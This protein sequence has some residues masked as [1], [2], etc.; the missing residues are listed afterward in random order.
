MFL[1]G[2]MIEN[3]HHLNDLIT[4]LV[5]SKAI[6][7]RDYYHY[8]DHNKIVLNE[9]KFILN[10]KFCYRYRV[11]NISPKTPYIGRS[12]DH[13]NRIITDYVF[14][15]SLRYTMNSSPPWTLGWKYDYNCSSVSK[16]IMDII[17]RIPLKYRN[18][19]EYLT[20][21]ITS[22]IDSINDPVNG[23]IEGRWKSTFSRGK[24][25]GEWKTSGE[26]F[27][28]RINNKFPVRY[29]Q[30]WVLS[31]LLTGIFRFLGIPA[32]SVRIDNCIIDIYKSGGIDCIESSNGLNVK[33]HNKINFRHIIDEERYEFIETKNIQEIPSNKGCLF[34]LNNDIESNDKDFYG[35]DHHLG[36]RNHCWNF[37]VWTEVMIG[38]EWCIFDPS[39]LSSIEDFSP[40]ISDKRHPMMIG[41]KFLGPIPIKY[42]KEG[43]IPSNYPLTEN[44]KYLF[45]C[46][47]G[48]IRC[49]NPLQNSSGSRTIFYL[50][51]VNYDSVKVYERTSRGS[52][53]DIT[54]KYKCSYD[55]LHINNPLYFNITGNN[56]MEIHVFK[57]NHPIGEYIIQL[58]ILVGNTPLYIHREKVYDI[59]NMD[60]LLFLKDE[61]VMKYRQIADKI[62]VMIYDKKKDKV[63]FQGIRA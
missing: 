35:I 52:K 17:S 41:K 47:N 43:N 25:P 44:F 38:K 4:F 18:D 60:F 61:R 59:N 3:D 8:K 13:K 11:E 19:I 23:L 54:S 33:S 55:N 50:S 62:T 21:Y 45:N 5:S 6:E 63:Y 30:C 1:Y 9:T 29:G 16:W 15:K 57:R 2:D 28:E 10:S 46:V 40:Y 56:I 22:K 7:N 51:N 12:I 24:E 48:T 34:S 27:R 49:W 20:T 31:D 26:I 14:N 58:C 36:K 37:H 32:K 39:P 42:I 53:L